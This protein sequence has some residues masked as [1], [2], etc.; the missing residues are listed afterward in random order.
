MERGY[1]NTYNLLKRPTLQTDFVLDASMA[2]RY[3]FFKEL[4]EQLPADF[5]PHFETSKDEQLQK[6][7]AQVHDLE[8]ENRALKEAIKLMGKG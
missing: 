7:E 6:L 1:K 2:L 3:N 5:P 8:T 4:A